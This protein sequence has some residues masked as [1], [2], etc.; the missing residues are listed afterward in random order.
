MNR[1]YYAVKRRIV[2]II[3][4]K[5]A[6]SRTKK[7]RFLPLIPEPVCWRARFVGRLCNTL[8]LRCTVWF[9]CFQWP[10]SICNP[11]CRQ[12]VWS[13]S[14]PGAECPEIIKTW[15][16]FFQNILSQ[17]YSQF[18]YR[19]RIYCELDRM[20]IRIVSCGKRCQLRALDGSSF[21]ISRIS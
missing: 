1:F 18:W 7:S 4:S 17:R 5:N 3:Q 16:R 8:L 13:S 11:S 10:G 12:R 6:R 20:H 9:E 15:Q 21:Q 2:V 19:R 14:P